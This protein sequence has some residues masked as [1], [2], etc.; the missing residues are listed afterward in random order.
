MPF[1]SRGYSGLRQFDRRAYER[2]VLSVLGIRSLVVAPSWIA[3][4]P[5]RG[6]VSCEVRGSGSP[7]AGRAGPDHHQ[8]ARGFG[9]CVALSRSVA[10]IY[11]ESMDSPG[12]RDFVHVFA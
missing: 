4:V 5:A 1:V 11:F 7:S 8:L 2:W 6:F 10:S 12:R 9:E 3:D